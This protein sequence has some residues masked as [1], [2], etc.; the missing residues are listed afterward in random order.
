MYLI[1]KNLHKKIYTKVSIN[2]IKGIDQSIMSH[3]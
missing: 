2:K 1:Y 3:E